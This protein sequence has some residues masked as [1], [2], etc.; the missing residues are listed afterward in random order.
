M[1]EE[2]TLLETRRHGIVLLPALAK[3]AVLAAAGAALVAAGWPGVV[4][5]APLLALAALV[6]L[7]ATWRWERT[8]IVVTTEQLV[9]VSGSL[10]RRRVAVA[11]ARAGPV[12]LDQ[13]LPGRLF[14]Y[15]TLVAGELEVPHVPQA[16]RVCA[17]VARLGSG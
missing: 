6:S 4:A 1:G 16:R 7:R 12:E 10:R 3:A 9:V 8:R 15:G 2:R 13:S 17:L 11:L 5:G 14:G